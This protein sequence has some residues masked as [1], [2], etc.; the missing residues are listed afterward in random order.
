MGA[1]MIEE[2]KEYENLL[3]KTMRKS[4]GKYYTPDF[5]IDYILNMTLKNL[6]V[7][8]NPFIKILDPTCGTGFFLERAYEMLLEKFENSISAINFNYSQENYE[9][10]GE[11]E[12]KLLKGKE[13]WVK[14]NIP[15]HILKNCIYGADIDEQALNIAKNTL[16]KKLRFEE[17]NLNLNLINCD[18]LIKWESIN[19]EEYKKFDLPVSKQCYTKMKKFWENQFELIIGNPPFVVLLKSEI[20]ENYREYLKA[21]YLTLGYKWNIFYL[22]M[23]RCVDKLKQGGINSFIIPDR[24]FSSRSYLSSRKMLLNNTKIINVTNF[25]NKVFQDAVVGIVCYVAEKTEIDNTYQF[26]LK[27]NYASEKD[28]D[29]INILQ[30]DII[31]SCDS[32]INILTGIKHATLISKINSNAEDLGAFCDVHVGMMIKDKHQHFEESALI[33]EKHKI[34]TGRDLTDYVVLNSE[35]YCNPGNANIFGGTKRIDKHSRYPK[36]FLRKTG[37]RIVASIDEEGIYAEQSVY[38]VIPKDV[39]TIYNLL[40]QISSKLCSYFYRE[41]LISNPKQYP[42]LQ[43]YDA[44][45]L[46]VNVELLENERFTSLIHDMI[47]LKKGNKDAD[48]QITEHKLNAEINE[49][50]YEAYKLNPLEIGVIEK[51]FEKQVDK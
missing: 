44:L 30:G 5:I 1:A 12:I 34:V 38:F 50:V 17:V 46:P 19:Y 41:C 33:Q 40:G 15:Y 22:V 7:L 8:K 35:R 25:S 31:K 42:Y 26:N 45:K 47:S 49:F 43:H 3:N 28:F 18:C 16:L 20:D 11:H 10:E 32:T 29:N 39:Q 23:E 37:N 36:I 6:D 51:Y 9:Y 27:L 21:N 48:S 2:G 14:E 13:Y 4:Q 24:Y